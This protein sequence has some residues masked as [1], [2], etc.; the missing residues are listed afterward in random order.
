MNY[1]S[2]TRFYKWLVLILVILNIAT[3][4]FLWISNNTHSGCRQHE[5]SDK[6]KERMHDR[7]DRFLK[8]ELELNEEQ[9]Q[10]FTDMRQSHFNLMKTKRNE[11]HSLK[12]DLFHL[13]FKDAGQLKIDSLLSAIGTLQMEIEKSNFDHFKLLGEACTPEQQDKLRHVIHGVFMNITHD[14]S[15]RD[16]GKSSSSQRKGKKYRKKMSKEETQTQ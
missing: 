4:S 2:D 1:F 15:G 5:H 9:I 12:K 3:L 7:N 16:H 14:N 8:K 11:I 13:V 6:F 10:L